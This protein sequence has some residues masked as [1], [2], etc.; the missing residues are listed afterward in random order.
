MEQRLEW[1]FDVYD[2][3]QD[4]FISR[5]E[6]ASILH[7]VYGMSGL[8]EQTHQLTLQQH[9]DRVFQKMDLNQD[10]IVT[11]EEFIQSC[12]KVSY[13]LGCGGKG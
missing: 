1:C 5:D 7:T 3:N 11:K 13:S 2:I 9:I 4:S 10:G 12:L 8:D 6:V